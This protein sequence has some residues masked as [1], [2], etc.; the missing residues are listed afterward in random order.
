MKYG[1]LVRD[2]IPDIIQRQGKTPAV[3]VLSDDEYRVY[4]NK[5]LLEEVNEYLENSCVEEFCDILEVLDAVRKSMNFSDAD[6]DAFKS[7]KAAQNG[8]FDKKLFLEEVVE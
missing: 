2:N 8:K 5:K 4:L 1:K 3:R 7:A 6:I